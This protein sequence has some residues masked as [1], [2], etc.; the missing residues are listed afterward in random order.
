MFKELTNFAH[1]RTGSQAFGFY[2][3]YLVLL[4]L[5]GGILAFVLVPSDVQ[6]EAEA[7][8]AGAAIGAKFAPIAVVTIG[9]LVAQAKKMLG[10]FQAIFMIVLAGVLAIAGGGLLGLIPVAYLTTQDA[11]ATETTIRGTAT[12]SDPSA[13]S[14]KK[15]RSS[16]PT[17][18]S[19]KTSTSTSKSRSAKK[20]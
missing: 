5:L 2:I 17:R 3:A 20:K 15:R 12:E 6:T 19:K 7:F 8:E 13:R 16:K 11:S 10:S 4:M 1:K 9:V 14:T 18:A